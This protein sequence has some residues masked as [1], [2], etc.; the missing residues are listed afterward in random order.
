MT[1]SNQTPLFILAPMDDV[2]E[3]VFRRIVSECSAPDLTMTEFVNVDGLASVGRARLMPRLNATMDTAPV[4]AQIWGKTPSNFKRIA[5]EIADGTIP[6]FSGIDINFGC[7]DK[8]VVKNE[9]CSA[10]AQPHLHE[11]AVEIIRAT[12]RGAGNMPVSIKTRLGFSSI[13]YSWHELLLAEKPSMLTV[14]VRTTKQMSKVPAQ[15]DAILPIIELRDKLSPETKIILNGDIK[16]RSQGQT[17]I[18]KFG[19]DGVM[20]GRGVFD[21]PYCFAGES[22][23]DSLSKEE[24]LTILKKH[25]TL[26]LH[27]YPNG[28]RKFDP[29]KKF[30]KIY[31]N[32]FDGAKELREQLMA[33]KSADEL[34]NRLN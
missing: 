32:G 12:K 28:E 27:A 25:V 21:D 33:C 14:H 29:L 4:I 8:S 31:C 3:T 2:T 5:S 16:T 7:P 22:P 26:W 23:W 11:K 24:K 18:E 19:V 6:G 9:C 1:K 10:L 15:W 17:L 30:C 13:E 34:L 20:I